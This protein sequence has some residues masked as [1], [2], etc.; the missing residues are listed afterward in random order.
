[1]YFCAKKEKDFNLHQYL[2]SF[3]NNVRA[4]EA[5]TSAVQL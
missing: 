2:L 4:G 5:G 1:M 3:S